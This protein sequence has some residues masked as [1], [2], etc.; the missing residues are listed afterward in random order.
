MNCNDVFILQNAQYGQSLGGGFSNQGRDQYDT[1]PSQLTRD[2]LDISQSSLSEGVYFKE[3]TITTADRRGRTGE[4]RS[5][6]DQPG[7]DQPYRSQGGSSDKKWTGHVRSRSEGASSG[8]N[9]IV[10]M[11]FIVWV[12]DLYDDQ[13]IH[14]FI[15]I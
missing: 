11:H 9:L 1:T 4:R 15:G 13:E 12:C 5:R 14:Y 8:G 3:A 10:D 6:F 2:P 7:D